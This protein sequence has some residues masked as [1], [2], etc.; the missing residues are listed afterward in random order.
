M[1]VTGDK[2]IPSAVG[3]SNIV[4]TLLKFKTSIS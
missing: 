3:H 4:D 2:W 1:W